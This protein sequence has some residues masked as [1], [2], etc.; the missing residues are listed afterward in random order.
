MTSSI[1]DVLRLMSSLSIPMGAAGLVLACASLSPAL[2]QL[3][4]SSPMPLNVPG[5]RMVALATK[6]N[7]APAIDGVL[8]ERMWQEA[9]PLGGFV[10][11]E[12]FEG[13]PGSERTEVR[14]LYDEQ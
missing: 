6:I 8:D 5:P 9:A 3:P 12:P 4:A 1:M 10:Q 14:L 11:A 7:E 13:M 2:A